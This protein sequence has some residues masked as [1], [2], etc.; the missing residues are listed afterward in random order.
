MI[1]TKMKRTAC[2]ALTIMLAAQALLLSGCG[3]DSEICEAA[4]AQVSAELDSLKQG[5]S[6]NLPATDG[7]PEDVSESMLEIYAEKLRD[8][9]YDILDA[10]PA[11]TEGDGDTVNVTVRIRTYDF[12]GIYLKTWKDQ[13]QTDGSQSDESQFYADLFARI[14]AADA[15]DCVNDAVVVC[16]AS[17]DDGRTTDIRTNEA[18]MNAISGDM[19]DQIRD[20]AEQ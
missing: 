6:G 11:E 14:A 7:F 15:K 9:D 2:V 3:A 18:L 5:K 4:A 10:E 1:R 13:M 19:I 8:F 12:G 20:L 17:G 16:T